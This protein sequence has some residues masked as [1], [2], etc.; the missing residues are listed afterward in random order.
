MNEDKLQEII[1]ER[2]ED[3]EVRLRKL[4]KNTLEVK[5]EL[6]N[7][8]KNQTDLKSLV[9]ETNRDYTKHLKEFSNKM[10]ELLGNNINTNNKIRLIDRKEIWGL[11]ALIIGFALPFFFK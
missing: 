3:H 5:Y 2:I 11:V 6:V 10:T 9:L 1:E 7:V 8:S 4:E